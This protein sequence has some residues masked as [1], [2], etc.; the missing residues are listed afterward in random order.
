MLTRNS[1]RPSFE[2]SVQVCKFVEGRLI[3]QQVN[4]EEVD[5][6]FTMAMYIMELENVVIFYFNVNHC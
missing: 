2:S 4:Q 1:E 3:Q 6:M 5:F